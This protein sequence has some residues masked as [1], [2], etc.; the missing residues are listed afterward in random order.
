MRI[1]DDR[2]MDFSFSQLAAILAHDRRVPA[3]G[4]LAK[5]GS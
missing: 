5:G 2:G 1:D 3:V 4:A